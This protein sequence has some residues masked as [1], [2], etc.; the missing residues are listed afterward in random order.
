[1][2]G[3]TIE[4]VKLT[5]EAAS[6]IFQTAIDA[7]HTYGF[8]YWAE[9]EDMTNTGDLV[10]SIT[11]RELD[12][13]CRKRTLDITSLELGIAKA[14]NSL[15]SKPAGVLDEDGP[16]GPTAEAILQWAMFGEQVYG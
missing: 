13:P 3:L 16:D 1:M 2:Q 10:T 11:L 15:D 5:P 6:S 8:G 12:K 14:L 7:G 9:M 4:R